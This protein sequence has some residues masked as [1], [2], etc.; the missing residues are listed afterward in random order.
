MCH[1][2]G[3]R[4]FP[5][6]FVKFLRTPFLPNTSERL[7]LIGSALVWRNLFWEEDTGSSFV[8]DTTQQVASNKNIQWKFALTKA[9]SYDDFRII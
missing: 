5:V 1:Q 6:N 9:P 7:R 8:A 2:I 4:C 3:H